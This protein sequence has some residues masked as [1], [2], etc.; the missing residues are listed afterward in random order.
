MHS[1]EDVR[2]L[3]IGSQ[4]S[5]T[6]SGHELGYMLGVVY[7]LKGEAVRNS[8]MLTSKQLRIAEDV[9]DLIEKLPDEVEGTE[10]QEHLLKIRNKFKLLAASVPV[11]QK[12]RKHTGPTLDF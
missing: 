1:S 4:V 7:V 10:L 12:I 11:V 9:E 6:A 2:L 5:N 3:K 8:D